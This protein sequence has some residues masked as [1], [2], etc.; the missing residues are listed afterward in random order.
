VESNYLTIFDEKYCNFLK[1]INHPPFVL[2]YNGN[3]DLFKGDLITIVGTLGEFNVHVLQRLHEYGYSFI[4]EIN[5]R[6]VN[7]AAFLISKN[8]RLLLY[9]S[10]GINSP[11]VKQFTN[12]N[13][14]TL[15]YSNVLR[16]EQYN[17]NN[18]NMF[19]GRKQKILFIN[20]DD[21]DDYF[22]IFAYSYYAKNILY[23]IV[24]TADQKIFD[25]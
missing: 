9:A 8:F 11:T 25:K 22:D 6:N 15:I 14:S 10:E 21:Y 23:K 5:K 7:D 12:L 19:L 17:I 16:Q 1:C 4:Y 3:V 24:Y 13:Q 18:L 2:F 20:Y